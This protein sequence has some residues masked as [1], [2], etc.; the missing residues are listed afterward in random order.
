MKNKLT[1]TALVS[2]MLVAG[3]TA[4]VAQT[5]VSG[6]LDLSYMAS[7]AKGNTGAPNSFRGFGKESQINLANKGKLNNGMDYAAGFSLEYDAPDAGTNTGPHEE[8]VYIDIISGNTTLSIGS[9]HTQN[10][11]SN[12]TIL[13][14]FGYLAVDSTIN[15]SGTPTAVAGLYSKGANSPYSA[16]SVSLTQKTPIGSF[17]ALYVPTAGTNLG[18][19]NDVH[20]SS[21]AIVAE[22]TQT[23]GTPESAYE[24]GFRGDLGV[25]GLTAMAFYN[26]QDKMDTVLTKND[27][28]GQRYAV[29]YVTG[30]FSI[31][32][33][34][35]KVDGVPTGQSAT[36]GLAG[37]DLKS[38]SI[39]L[40]YAITPNLSAS[41]TRGTSEI[42]NPNTVTGRTV[43][44]EEI[45]MIALGYSLG[46]VAIQAQ[47]KQVDNIAG[48][49]G[50]D[51]DVFAVK[52][53]T[54]F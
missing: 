18:G 44:K 28:K 20:N 4:S 8:N 2:S 23:R 30:P 24:L 51:V 38:K 54:R 31:A 33:D 35:A 39:G 47:Y 41:I 15:I 37:E 29:T 17:S 21:S 19:L 13:A 27:M 42:S 6:N 36:A 43:A 50:A 10:P 1:T 34:Y 32:G 53:G 14:G 3:I 45:D 5:T 46:P 48:Y 26:K 22:P 7:S 52:V 12:P 40:G 9:D 11:D 49:T 25:K 16:Y